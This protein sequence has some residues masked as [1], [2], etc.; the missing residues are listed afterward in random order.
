MSTK[1][2]IALN[3][4]FRP[5]S[6]EHIALTW[7]QSG[8]YDRISGAKTK[9]SPGGIPMILP[10]LAEEDDLRELLNRCDG[11]VLAGCSLDLDPKR[12]GLDKHPATRPMA[13]RRED[14]DRRLAKLAVEMQLPILAIGAGMQTL[15][16]VC[17]GTLYQHIPEDFPKA[18]QHRDHVERTLRHVINIVPGTILDRMYGP[19]EIRVNSDHHMCVD[20]LAPHFKVSAHAP[21]GV[22]EAYESVD[23]D[24]FCVGVQWHP[25]S[26]TAAELDMQVFE[27]FLEACVDRV[28]G[29]VP[30][31]IPF[32]Q[33]AAPRKVLARA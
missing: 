29:S 33:K 16:V 23:P 12:L 10:P 19:G 31:I 25:E 11:V 15:N 6:P 2:I 9:K 8:Y 3:A 30:T 20:Q 17:G 21:D 18:I 1:P 13:A 14:F 24:W 26:D 5:A 27:I 7:L 28:T 4:D 22:I 32:P